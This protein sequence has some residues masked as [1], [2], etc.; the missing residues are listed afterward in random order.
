MHFKVHAWHAGHICKIRHTE[1]LKHVV[2][3]FLWWIN[4]PEDKVLGL[5]WKGA[6]EQKVLADHIPGCLSDLSHLMIGNEWNLSEVWEPVN[7]TTLHLLYEFFM[8][9]C[10]FG[11]LNS[12]QDGMPSLNLSL[13]LCCRDR[14]E[15]KVRKPWQHKMSWDSFPCSCMYV[16]FTLIGFVT[17][18]PRASFL[19]TP[20]RHVHS[21]GG[22]GAGEA[23]WKML[24]FTKT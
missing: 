2:T 22:G 15:K 1:T 16:A 4:T 14:Q 8:S 7:K 6:D 20:L 24:I 21:V 18:K 23:V 13:M 17:M 3:L 5:S 9:S 10:I 11:Y 19:R 12:E